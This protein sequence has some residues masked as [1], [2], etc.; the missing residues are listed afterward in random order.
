MQIDKF[1][2][3]LGLAARA[4]KVVQGEGRVADSIRCGKAKLV[5]VSEDASENTKK[6]FQNSCE[7]YSIP[8][9]VCGDRYEN[10][11]ATGKSFAV[12]MAV[13]DAGFADVLKEN[14]Q[15]Q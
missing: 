9:L 7:Y 12:V 5:I 11:H 3:M 13:C 1:Y 15:K 8:Q 6:K 14:A 2:R 4:G 10:G